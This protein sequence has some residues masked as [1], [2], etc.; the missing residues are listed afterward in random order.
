MGCVNSGQ[1]GS[2]D[3]F[4]D[5]SNG[6]NGFPVSHSNACHWH[7]VVIAGQSLPTG[8]SCKAAVSGVLILYI[9]R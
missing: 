1:E 9:I 6:W 5:S 4:W 7:S 8:D 2:N 3:R